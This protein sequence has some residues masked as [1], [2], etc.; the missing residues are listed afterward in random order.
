MN[1]PLSYHDVVNAATPSCTHDGLPA[2]RS[3]SHQNGYSSQN[4]SFPG[5]LWIGLTTAQSILELLPHERDLSIPR[6]KIQQKRAATKNLDFFRTSAEL[7]THF[8][9]IRR[10]KQWVEAFE[11]RKITEEQREAKSSKNETSGI[12]WKTIGILCQ[13]VAS[14]DKMLEHRDRMIERR[15]RTIQRRNRTIQRRKRT[16]ERRDKMIQRKNDGLE[17]M[18]ARL[19]AAEA[20][21]REEEQESSYLDSMRSWLFS[22][23]ESVFRVAQRAL[24]SWRPIVETLTGP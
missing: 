1:P 7:R 16:I 15:D 11:R 17:R 22:L 21:I 2:P 10:V 4:K 5:A 13:K 8:G 9:T 19:A 18:S 6:R 20:A 12:Q 3:P 23:A 24:V 14:R